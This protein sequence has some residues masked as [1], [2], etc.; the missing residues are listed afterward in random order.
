M[1]NSLIR[2]FLYAAV[3]LT[4]DILWGYTGILTFGQS[5]F[6]GIG[7]YA[8]GLIFT[9]AGFGTGYA[10]LALVTG[11]AVAIIVAAV[12]GWLAFYH[13][14][15]PLYGSVVTLVL[16]IVVSQ[17]LYSGGNFTGSSSGLSGF[18]S[19]DVSIEAWFWIAGSFLVVLT[20]G[21]WLFV[22]SDAGR[23][24]VAIREN[25]QRCEYVG[26]NVSRVKILLLVVCAAI[27]AVA[28]YMFAGVQM[29]VAPEYA[30]FVFGTEL[31]I[32][33]A[34]GGRGTLIGPVIGTLVL[35]VSTSYLSGNLPFVWKLVI[36]F[37][38]VVVIVALPQGLM[39]LI[40]AA[41]R[42]VFGRKKMTA[43]FA[44]RLEP[45]VEQPYAGLAG[46]GSRA[47]VVREVRK[48][49]GSLKVLEGI[50]FEAKRSELLSLVGPNGAGKTTLMRCIADGNERS[51]G[52]VLL[53]DHDIRKLPPYACV[54]FG[55]GRKFQTANVFETLTVAEALRIART[56]LAPPSLWKREETL[57]LPHASMQVVRA[58]GLHERLGI[59]AR[60]LSHGMKQAL[61]LTMVLALEPSVLLL[62]EPT[63]GLT[64][65]E[66]TLIGGILTDLARNH[67]LCI[68]L[69]EHD[70]DFVREISSRV[71]VL[72]QGRILLDG[73]VAEVV[74]SELVR[75][76]YSGGGHAVEGAGA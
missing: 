51:G 39:P 11:I 4:V 10:A 16:P 54:A 1:V 6:F 21:A 71:I 76:I 28:G 56:R 75:T 47:L 12:V 65:P 59:E 41:I 14:A 9:H 50:E 30:G 69:V 13:S 2:A 52:T 7:A 32:W 44:P 22:R 18:E 17:I 73:T 66:R 19:F 61:E 8:A 48:Q 43:A 63:A 33:V 53:N 67:Q 25:E 74:E 35:D 27:A 38:F 40:K 60:H 70:L 58:T 37:A 31:L 34:L 46:A 26:I 55:V 20:A 24:L 68:L 64:K 42:R 62:D 5:A 72:H 49:F 3:A 36:G 15:S 23:I 45:A 29:V 57:A